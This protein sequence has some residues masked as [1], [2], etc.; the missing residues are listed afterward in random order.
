M[1]SL[2]RRLA[3]DRARRFLAVD[4]QLPEKREVRFY[5]KSMQT[6]AA[7]CSRGSDGAGI[8]RDTVHWL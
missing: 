6:G 5:K 4:K 8:L 2:S 1:E 7:E 3:T